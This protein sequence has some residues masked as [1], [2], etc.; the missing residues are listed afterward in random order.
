M[1]LLRPLSALFT[2]CLTGMRGAAGGRQPAAA[3]P[4]WSSFEFLLITLTLQ[5]NPQEALPSTTFWASRGPNRCLPFPP[6]VHAFI[7]IAHKVKHSHFSGC[8]ARRF[9]STFAIARYR[10]FRSSTF[11]QEKVPTSLESALSESWTH[12]LDLVG[13]YLITY[14]SIGDVM[15]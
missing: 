12:D 13:T 3:K 6:P 9:S 10:A 14:H 11:A 5:F 4:P 15:W 2:T 8:Y 1:L 7:S